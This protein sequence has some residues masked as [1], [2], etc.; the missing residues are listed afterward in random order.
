MSLGMSLAQ[1]IPAQIKAQGLH[2]GIAQQGKGAPASTA[3]I[4]HC[5]IRTQMSQAEQTFGKRYPA[6]PQCLTQRGTNRT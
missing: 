4:Q 2:T 5:R 6:W 1:K 3:N